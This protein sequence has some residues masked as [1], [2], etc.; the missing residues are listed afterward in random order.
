MALNFQI[1]LESK[2]IITEHEKVVQIIELVKERVNFVNEL[3]EQSKF[4]FEAPLTYDEQ[5]FKKRWKEDTSVHLKSIIE[6]INN[7][8]THQCEPL[9]DNVVSYITDNSLNM[10]QIM[11]CLR[12]VIVGAGMGP[13][14][15]TIIELIGKDEAIKRIT[16][17]IEKITNYELRIT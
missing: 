16:K 14:L 5:V 9:H 6:I 3:W 13:D 2:G 8:I 10:G 15:F 11:N 1:I 17:G 12:L 4:F 7:T